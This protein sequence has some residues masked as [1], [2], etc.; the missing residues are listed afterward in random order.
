MVKLWGIIV[1]LVMFFV[2]DSQL[3]IFVSLLVDPN[4]ILISDAFI[5]PERIHL[6]QPF[7]RYLIDAFSFSKFHFFSYLFDYL[8]QDRRFL[9]MPF[10]VNPSL[11]SLK[12][13]NG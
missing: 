6:Y 3:K 11:R 4:I 13:V 9:N 2:L 5:F 10:T 1:I 7:P 8:F 12:N